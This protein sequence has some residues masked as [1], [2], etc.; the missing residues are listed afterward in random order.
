MDRLRNGDEK[1]WR[2]ALERLDPGTV[3]VK[4]DPFISGPDPDGRIPGIAADRPFPTRSFVEAWLAE[5]RWAIERRDAWRFRSVLI[6]TI[7]AAV[8]AVI[9]AIPVL[10]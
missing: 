4:L 2:D 9:A 3:H 1:R 6:F 7:I 10:R 8:A 5:K